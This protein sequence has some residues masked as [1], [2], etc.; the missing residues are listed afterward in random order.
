VDGEE[1]SGGE[2]INFVCKIGIEEKVSYFCVD[3]LTSA[4]HSD[5]PS[6]IAIN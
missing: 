1:K 3:S 2:H 6:Q 4:I 5:L